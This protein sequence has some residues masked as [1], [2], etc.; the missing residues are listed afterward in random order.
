MSKNINTRFIF[1]FANIFRVLSVHLLSV[2]PPVLGSLEEVSLAVFVCKGSINVAGQTRP[3]AGD[4]T[5][6]SGCYSVLGE[7][8]IMFAWKVKKSC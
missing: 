5:R 8:P 2:I 1:T 4:Q 7:T 6:V 3:C